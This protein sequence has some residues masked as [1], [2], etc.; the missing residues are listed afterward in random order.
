MIMHRIVSNANDVLPEDRDSKRERRKCQVHNLEARGSPPLC[1]TKT[2]T[3]PKGVV[4]VLVERIIRYAQIKR[5][6]NPIRSRAHPMRDFALST[7]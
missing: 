3:I 1:S 7:L 6:G 2:K 5:E 4:F